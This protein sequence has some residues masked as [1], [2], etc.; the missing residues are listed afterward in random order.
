[1]RQRGQQRDTTKNPK[2]NNNNNTNTK[3]GQIYIQMLRKLAY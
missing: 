3:S 1:M 2:K